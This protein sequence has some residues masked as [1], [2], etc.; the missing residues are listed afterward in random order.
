M[1]SIVNNDKQYRANFGRGRRTRLLLAPCPLLDTHYV[2]RQTIAIDQHVCRKN[3]RKRPARPRNQRKGQGINKGMNDCC[4][5]ICNF[6]TRHPIGLQHIVTQQV[7]DELIHSAPLVPW[8]QAA[9]LCVLRSCDEPVPV[10][11]FDDHGDYS[12]GTV[13][14]VA[15]LRTSVMTLMSRPDIKTI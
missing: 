11:S 5:R 12:S 8:Q 13:G 15:R 9:R 14:V 1:N 10:Y 6:G 7:A 4:K 3:N 2:V